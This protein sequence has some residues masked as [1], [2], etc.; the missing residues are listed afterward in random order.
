MDRTIVFIF[1]MNYL[2]VEREIK[3]HAKSPHSKLVP[4]AFMLELG[5]FN[6]SVI[7]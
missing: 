1:E 2:E 3:D 4:E 6:N 5:S 7:W